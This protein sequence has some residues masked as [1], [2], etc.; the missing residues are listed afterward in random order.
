MRKWGKDFFYTA[1]PNYKIVEYI[2]FCEFL[3]DYPRGLRKDTTTFAQGSMTIYL[4]EE[5]CAWYPYGKVASANTDNGITRYVIVDNY[6][7]LYKT[8]TGRSV[9]DYKA[10]SAAAMLEGREAGIILSTE[11]ELERKW[12]ETL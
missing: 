5:I 11:S 7:E 12:R 3:E 10:Q 6:E 8:R 9:K 2:E 1:E 4:D